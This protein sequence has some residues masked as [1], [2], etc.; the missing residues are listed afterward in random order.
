MADYTYASVFWIYSIMAL[1]VVGAAFFLYRAVRTGAVS[2]DEAPKYRML[3]D[4]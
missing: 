1:F 3:Q 4:D 2:G